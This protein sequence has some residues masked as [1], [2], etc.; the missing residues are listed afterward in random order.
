MPDIFASPEGSCVP[1][2]NELWRIAKMPRRQWSESEAVELAKEMTEALKTPHGTME[3]RPLQAVALYEIGTEGGLFGPL[4]CGMGKTVVSLLA[5]VV[6][7]AD[8]P[9]LL[10]PAK[11]VDKTERDRRELA[12]HWE[13]PPFLRI[14]TY[15]W[16]GRTQAADALEK[17]LPDI[18]IADEVH[19][20]SNI[21][22]AAVARRVRRFM[23]DYPETR[24]IAM[25]GTVTKRSLHDFAHMLH[26]SHHAEKMPVPKVYSDLEFWADALDER[27]GQIKR[28]DPGALQILCDESERKMWAEGET[29]RAARS[30]FRRRL[31][32]TAGVVATY[33]TPIDATL[34]LNALEPPVSSKIEGAFETLRADWETPNGWTFSD[35]LR[36]SAHARE[37]AL[38]FFY[39]WDPRPPRDWMEARKAWHQFVRRTLKHSHKLDSPKQVALAYPD[40]PELVEWRRL[41]PSF[42][43]N[44]VPVWLDDTMLEVCA[45]WAH[46]NRGIVWTEHTFFARRLEKDFGLTYYGEE[47]YSAAGKFIDDHPRD[48]PLIASINSN[49]EGRNLQPW[50]TA[51]I[52][53]AP[54]NG[55]QWEQVI[56]RIHRDGQEADEVEFDILVNCAEHVGAFWQAMSDCRYVEDNIG[57]PQKLLLAGVSVPTPDDIAARQ[58]PR[59]DKNWSRV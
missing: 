49:D 38:S 34:T 29:R 19:K 14:M 8:R 23:N 41:K 1:Y 44:T 33:E 4:R 16:L 21:R 36:M 45:N 17:F 40:A 55:K 57:S 39:V 6:A 15:D 7:L 47:G 11:L 59:W 35:G 2:S 43:P 52:T 37:L 10:I 12:H 51:L 54:A 20:L 25:S 9:L 48:E 58:G 22:G 3:L 56:S 27:K 42:K 50:S 46:K 53:S 18:I 5:P 24:F 26:W 28:A 30:A 32:E 31:I 13:L